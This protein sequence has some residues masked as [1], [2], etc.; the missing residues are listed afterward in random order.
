MMY[1]INMYRYINEITVY[2]RIFKIFK[3]VYFF[4]NDELLIK[5][6]INLLIFNYFVF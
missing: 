6:F 3:S 4:S 2:I 5:F 1:I